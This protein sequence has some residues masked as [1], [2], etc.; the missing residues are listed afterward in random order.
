MKRYLWLLVSALALAG[1]VL[2]LDRFATSGPAPREPSTTLPTV[3]LEITVT[4][5]G[6]IAPSDAAVP[7]DHRVR[8]TVRN[9]SAAPAA[10]ALL[11][12]EDRVHV[13]G[14]PPDSAWRG[15]FVADRPGDDFSWVLGG[16]PVGRLR[17]TGSHL[18]EEHR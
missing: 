17:V 11:G 3:V 12:Y 9:A 6:G 1:L 4:P 10:L 13:A 16:E 8:L 7:K 15:E 5:E 14:V 2:A 18:V